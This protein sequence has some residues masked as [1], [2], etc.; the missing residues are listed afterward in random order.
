M[1]LARRCSP[2]VVLGLAALIATGHEVLAQ[3]A[4]VPRQVDDEAYTA[5]IKEYT[6]D[7]RVID[8]AGR[9]PA[10]LAD[11]AVAAEGARAGSPAR[12]TS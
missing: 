4:R 7:P 2:M 11:G 1:R 8:R 6:Q 3:P 9:P 12:R 10:G 5:K